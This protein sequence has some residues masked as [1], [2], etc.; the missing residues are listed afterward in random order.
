MKV[1]IISSMAST[2]VN[3]RGP[4]IVEMVRRGHQVVAFAPDHDAKTR[5]ALE[6]LGAMPIDYAMS[7]TGLNPL[8]DAV[9]L[10]QLVRLLR[11]HR[12]D[13]S[14]A[15]F[16]KP[17]IYGTLAA[18]LAGVPHRFAMMEGMGFVFTHD[19]KPG[20]GHRLL[21]WLSTW[22]FRLSLL[23]ATR[24]LLLNEDDYR[25]FVDRRLVRPDKASILGGIGVDLLEWSYHVPKTD[26]VEF[27]FIGRLLRDKGVEE[28]AAAARIVRKKFPSTR[29]VMLGGH[30]SNPTAIPLS[31]VQQW[32]NEGTV[33]W[34]GHVPIR[35]ALLD[36]S[37]FVLPSYREGVPRSTQEAM[38]IG[39]PVVTT[40]V[41]GCRETI[42]EGV[43]GFLVPARDATA[44][45]EAM[46]YFVTHPEKIVPMGLESRRIAEDRFD[47]HRQNCKLLDLIGL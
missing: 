34:P 20:I 36:A 44:L 5:F 6:Q 28:F 9:A 14:F 21:Q 17:V 12:P 40:D 2:L 8:R 1:A 42:V 27:V 32:V 25:E 26:P 37:V 4:L 7:R 18:K 13:T 22:L 19:E 11:N 46:T 16:I 41:P 33:Q 24:L 23:F 31:R 3:F 39:L 29:F 35:P 30:D 45:A 38:A 10:A 43:N 15:Y 47:V